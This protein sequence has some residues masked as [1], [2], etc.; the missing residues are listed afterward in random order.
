MYSSYTGLAR[1]VG[2]LA[3][4]VF[5]WSSH[6]NNALLCRG[7][8]SGAVNQQLFKYMDYPAEH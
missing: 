1:V 4:V 2:M 8:V 3:L 5:V 6:R 7:L